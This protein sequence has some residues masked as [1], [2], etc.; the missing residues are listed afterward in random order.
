M[1]SVWGMFSPEAKN[2]AIMTEH[3]W[4]IPKTHVYDATNPVARDFYWDDLVGKLFARGWDAL[5][6]DRS[7]PEEDWPHEGDAILSNKPLAIGN[8][9]EYTNIFP[10]LHTAGVQQHWMAENQQKRVFLL[11]R[12]AFLG[13]QRVGAA[14]WSGDIYSTWWG[15][16]PGASRIEL[17]A[18]RL[19]LL[20]NRCRRILSGE[21]RRQADPRL[22]EPVCALVR[23]RNVLSHLS[24]A[25]PSPGERDMELPRGRAHSD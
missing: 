17:C 7:E 13:Q 12:S 2:Y 5:W 18:L 10:L 6:L 8:G 15:L 11:T 9:A 22:P 20:D 21:Q 19:S 14:V 3:H 16:S 4:D 24:H 23:V 25:R 1:I